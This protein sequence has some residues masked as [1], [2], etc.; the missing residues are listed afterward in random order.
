M[1]N[2]TITLADIAS[3]IAVIEAASTR[4]AIKAN[5]LVTVGDLYN[6]L[7]AFMAHAKAQVEQSQ[8]EANA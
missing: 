7:Q 1:E 6:R 5:E 8:G 4:G 2:P 3:M